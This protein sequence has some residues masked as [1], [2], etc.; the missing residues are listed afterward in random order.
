VDKVVRNGGEDVVPLLLALSEAANC[1][2]ELAYLG[3]GPIED[4]LNYGNDA[5]IA[6]LVVA[7]RQNSTM[8]I[9][10]TTVW[11]H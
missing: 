3:A 4:L 5:R 10:R 9:S 1:D 11:G 6:E 8:A 2:S 7:V